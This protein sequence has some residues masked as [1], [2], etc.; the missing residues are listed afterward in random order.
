[1]DFAIEL[2]REDDGRWI[3]EVVSMPDVMVYGAT[4]SEAREQ[5]ESLAFRVLAEEVDTVSDEVPHLG[6]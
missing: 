3:A 6:G 5:V 2:E 4:V 1:M